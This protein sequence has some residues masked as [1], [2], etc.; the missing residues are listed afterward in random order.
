LGLTGRILIAKEGIN[1]TVEGTLE[2]T[3]KYKEHLLNDPR[4]R[5]MGIKTSVGNGSAFPRLTIKV[6]DEIVA[7]KFPK[8]I[9]PRERTGKYLPSHEL[10]RMYEENK[11]FVVLDMRN[12]YEVAGGHFD[13]TINL[14]LKASRDL[15]EAIKKLTIHKDTMIVTTCTGG[16]RCEK[17]SAYLL[18][19]GFTNVSQLHNG[20]HDFMQKYPGE[21]FKGTLFTFDNRITMD[22]GGNREIVGTCTYCEEKN[23]KYKNCANTFCN[24][25]MLVCDNC[26]LEK[27]AKIYCGKGECVSE[28]ALKKV[29]V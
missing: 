12:D 2:Q 19:Q 16:I 20:M 7:T 15:P 11:D 14:G 29:T 13:K 5:Q 4:F 3:K 23:E 6:R 17:M 26:Y 24:K 21:H 28:S 10:K 27:E 1:G 9:N 8:H 22:F 18:D 25:K